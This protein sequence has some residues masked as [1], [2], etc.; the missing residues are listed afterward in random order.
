MFSDSNPFRSVEVCHSVHHHFNR[1][2]L[3]FRTMGDNAIQF[4]KMSR[5]KIEESILYVLNKT[6][7]VQPRILNISHPQ[8]SQIDQ[9]M[10]CYSNVAIHPG[11]TGPQFYAELVKPICEGFYVAGD[12]FDY[13]HA[14]YVTAA[15]KTATLAAHDIAK[16]V[17]K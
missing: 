8:W 4:N 9:F 10:G 16:R 5:E 13:H 7:D 2:V 11:M 12:A 14:G 17:Q 15:H 3:L 1:K 6:L